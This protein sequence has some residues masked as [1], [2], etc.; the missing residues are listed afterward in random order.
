MTVVKLLLALLLV[1]VIA[2]PLS[3]NVQQIIPSNA[4]AH[5]VLALFGLPRGL[6]PA[7]VN[8]LFYYH[9]M[10][11]GVLEQGSITDLEGIEVKLLFVYVTVTKIKMRSPLFPFIDFVAGA[12]VDARDVLQERYLAT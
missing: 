4:T 7:S 5:D 10:I 9:E 8:S 6:L 12:I 1:G 3:S 11:T 2:S